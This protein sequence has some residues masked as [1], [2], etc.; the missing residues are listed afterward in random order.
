MPDDKALWLSGGKDSRLLLECLITVGAKFSI[1]TFGEGWTRDQRRA[2]DDL[3]RMYN[4]RVYSYPPAKSV[5]VGDG[6]GEFSVISDY[7]IGSRGETASL[8][9]DLVDGERCLHDVP[10]TEMRMA[11]PPLHFGLHLL[12]TKRGEGHWVLR[13]RSFLR[14]KTMAVGDAECLFP[15]FA[16]RDAEVIEALG[17]LGV[18]WQEPAETAN[19][20]NVP[21]CTRCLN[22]KKTHCPKEN[23]EIEPLA[24]SPT[25]NLAAWHV[26]AGI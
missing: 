10:V 11:R 17:A 9:R 20:G 12:G 21:V 18:E 7:A 5:M 4:L 22:G 16:W 6:K 26:S 23:R 19:G 15:L 13:N 24:W 25:V 8:F 1:L 3:T 2:V 14:R